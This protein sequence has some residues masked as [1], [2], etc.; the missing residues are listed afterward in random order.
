MEMDIAS[1]STA[2]AT[3]D[4]GTSVGVAVTK[5][6]METME[7]NSENLIQNMKAMELSVTPHLGSHFDARI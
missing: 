2:L 1:L 5:L 3:Q 6:G 7:Q 4:L